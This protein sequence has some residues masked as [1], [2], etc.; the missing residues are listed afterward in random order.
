[1]KDPNDLDTAGNRSIEDDIAADWKASQIIGQLLAQP[2]E[3]R[4][5]GQHADLLIEQID[6]CVCARVAIVGDVFPDFEDISPGTS[7][8][9]DCR[10]YSVVR[11]ISSASHGVAGPL[12][13]PS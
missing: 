8:L 7:T 13:S 9:E 1:M 4:L 5:S 6:E 10:H 12:S 2:T 11:L 3:C